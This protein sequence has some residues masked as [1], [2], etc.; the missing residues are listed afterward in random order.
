MPKAAGSFLKKAWPSSG[1]LVG[2]SVWLQGLG[3]PAAR[4]ETLT[5]DSYANRAP[6][7]GPVGYME[8]LP[9]LDV[10]S[11]SACHHGR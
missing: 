8:Q 1:K 10:V 4:W 7:T 9:E 2:G 11:F 3:S 5:A 6:Q